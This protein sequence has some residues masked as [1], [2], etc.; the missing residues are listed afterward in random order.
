MQI[1]GSCHCETISFALTWSPDPPEIAAR[2]C[3]CSFCAKHGGVWTAT[4][5]GALVVRIVDPALVAAYEQGTRT[6]TFHVCTRC[7]VV[8]VV[9]S[10]ID[11]RLYAV[12]NAN[13]FDGAARSLVRASPIDFD[14]EATDAR[15]ARRARHWI[16]DVRFV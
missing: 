10:R 1:A 5:T 12:V 11:G 7:G 9:T 4:R 3:A 16:A 13:T 14:G 2:A 6:A 8:P 15:L